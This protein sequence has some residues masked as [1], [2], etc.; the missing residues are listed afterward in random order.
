MN[1]FSKKPKIAH[2]WEYRYTA[3]T[4]DHA[5]KYDAFHCKDCGKIE[6]RY[7]KCEVCSKVADEV[8]KDLDFIGNRSYFCIEHLSSFEAR[9]KHLELETLRETGN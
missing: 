9:E 8:V 5:R 3:L 2:N 1:I 7:W 6:W 4:E